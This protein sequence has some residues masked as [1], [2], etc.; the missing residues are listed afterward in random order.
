MGDRIVVRP[1][2]VVL[3]ALPLTATMGKSEPLASLVRNPFFRPDV[4]ELVRLSFADWEGAPGESPVT[5]TASGLGALARHIR[6][7]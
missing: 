1:S 4:H 7:P 3:G 6:V 2:Q 5:L